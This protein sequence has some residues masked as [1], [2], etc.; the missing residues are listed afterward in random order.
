MEYLS[1]KSPSDKV[2]PTEVV[3]SSDQVW[4]PELFIVTPKDIPK[5]APEPPTK[6]PIS[7]SNSVDISASHEIALEDELVFS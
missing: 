5:E 6:P 3:D 4:S 2:K 1:S 7:L